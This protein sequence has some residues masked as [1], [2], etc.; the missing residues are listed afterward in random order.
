M[1]LTWQSAADYEEMSRVA[2]G[3]VF[4]RVA[5]KLGGGGRMVLGLATGNTMLG[6]YDRLARLLNENRLP[7]DRLHTVNLDEY[8]GADGCW[9][10]PGHPLSYHAYMRRQFFDRLD[11][12]LGFDIGCARFPEPNDPASID[13]WIRTAGGIDVQLLGIGFNGHIG[14]NEPMDETEISHDAYAALPSRVVELSELTIDTNARLTAG[15]DRSAVPR[16]AVT[17]GMAP[18]LD[19]HE[20]LLLACFAE[21]CPALRALRDG[22]SGPGL[23]AGYLA[24]HPDCTILYADDR[25]R[26]DADT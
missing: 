6:L 25:V 2:A 9:V 18:I 17:L 20:I 12:A 24:G 22:R 15:G 10:D 8:V 26:L 13:R 11:P 23:P 14:F 3:S 16:K 5:E 4:E 7:L 1:A 21:Q 19:A